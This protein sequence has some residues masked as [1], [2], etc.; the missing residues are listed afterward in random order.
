MKSNPL[1]SVVIPTHNRSSYLKNAINSVLNQTYTNIEIIVV[2]DNSTDNTKLVVESFNN[3]KVR[4]IK[5]HKNLM[6]AGSRNVGINLSQGEI[7]G[8]LD[9]DD[10]WYNDKL[11]L[12][13]PLFSEEKVG[14]VY[15]GMNLVFIE[16][17]LSYNT[18]PSKEGNIIR[19]MLIEN[20]VGGTVSVLVRKSI[21]E[22]EKFDT[23]FPAREE[24]DLWIRV[25]KTHEARCVKRPV[26]KANYR[27]QIKRV[28]TNVDSYVKGIELLNKKHK[29][30]VSEKLT[31]KEKNK[32]KSEQLFFLGSQSVKVY[33]LGLAR[34]YYYK[35]IV[36]RPSI[37]AIFS[38]LLTFL[39][40]KTILRVRDIKSKIKL[41]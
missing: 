4:Y 16:E 14:L 28:S 40:V 19:E 15:G 23:S 12:Q 20:A 26:V 33:N 24:Y 35:S 21:L 9:D 36:K 37:K 29:R 11:A 7:V 1:V 13:V 6:A 2:D 38:F 17:V 3:S 8:F 39:G 31:S 30:L 5:N 32:R 18:Q 25:L 41:K 10:E 22:K 34:K 27:N